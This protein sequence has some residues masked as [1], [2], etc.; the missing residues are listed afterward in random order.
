[1]ASM[2]N[3]ATSSRV[4]TRGSGTGLST[5]RHL[6]GGRVALFPFPLPFN[7]P[8]LR[9]S[10]QRPES[11]DLRQEA[12]EGSASPAR[13]ISDSTSQSRG[14]S[15]R[16]PGIDAVQT[17]RCHADNSVSVRHYCFPCI[18]SVSCDNS[19]SVHHYCF[20][21]IKSISWI[22]GKTSKTDRR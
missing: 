5:I 4:T 22:H 10:A 9:Q 1:L 6:S 11:H 15:G 12:L 7:P 21:C 18:K 17:I 13:D 2:A 14:S 19:V 20:P 16:R 8:G 3:S